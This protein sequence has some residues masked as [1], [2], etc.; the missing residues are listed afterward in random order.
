ML[1][2]RRLMNVSSAARAGQ[3]DEREGHE[4]QIPLVYYRASARPDPRRPSTLQGEPF[5]VGIRWFNKG[6]EL[7]SGQAPA[8]RV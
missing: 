7:D 2:R 6:V 1:K 4:Y 5:L 8:V 3:R